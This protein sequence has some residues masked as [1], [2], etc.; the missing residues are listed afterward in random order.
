MTLEMSLAAS[1]IRSS[2]FRNSR[3][4]TLSMRS[5]KTYGVYKGESVGIV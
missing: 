5:A 2:L 1:A 4:K 3:L